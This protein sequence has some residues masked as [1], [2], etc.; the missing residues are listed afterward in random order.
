MKQAFSSV[1]LNFHQQDN[2]VTMGPEILVGTEWV[3][4]W[5]LDDSSTIPL[6]AGHS[7]TIVDRIFG[8][9]CGIC[10]PPPQGEV[11]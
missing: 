5:L 1:T 9:N 10:P 7:A 3:H 8:W 2:A 4:V 11:V 6:V